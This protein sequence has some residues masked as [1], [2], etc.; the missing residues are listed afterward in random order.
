MLAQVLNNNFNHKCNSYSS[1]CFQTAGIF[2]G[3]A[4]TTAAD[5]TVVP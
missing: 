2:N 4:V 3:Q 5:G 1:P